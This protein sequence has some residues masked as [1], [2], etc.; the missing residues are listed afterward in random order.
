MKKKL[1]LAKNFAIASTQFASQ[2]NAILG[3]R[4]SGKT[5]TAMKSAEEVLECGIPIIVYDP[6][7][8]WKHIRSGV[9]GHRGYPVIVAGGDDD[10]DIKLTPDNA[11]SIVRA[12]MK[13][14]VSII[15]DLYS[16]DLANKSKWIKIVQE[17]I[18][19]LMYENRDHGL[20]LIYLEEAAEFI[21][22]RIMPQQSKVYAA[23]E[24]VARMGRNSSLGLCIINQ[25]AEEINKAI[26]ELCSLVFLHKQ[27]GKNSLTSI[28]KWFELLGVDFT[29]QGE[30]AIK[31]LPSLDK[32]ECM[33]INTNAVEDER[34]D[35]YD[36]V[37]I[38]PKKTFHPSP[39]KG[40]AKKSKMKS[41]VNIASFIK[42]LNKELSPKKE[43]KHKETQKVSSRQFA[44]DKKQNDA[45]KKI[46][47][48]VKE[49]AEK[50]ATISKLS[51]SVSEYNKQLKIAQEEIKTLLKQL[52]D[53]SHLT[54]VAI[55]QL[56]GIAG[57]KK[58]IS[59]VKMISS[60]S[61]VKFSHTLP[62]KT[63]KEL[64]SDVWSKDNKKFSLQHKG[65]MMTSED[66]VNWSKAS[67]KVKMVQ[68]VRQSNI[69]GIS[70]VELALQCGLAH[71]SGTYALY[72]R[73]LKAE[74][75][76]RQGNKGLF[77]VDENISKYPTIDGLPEDIDTIMVMWWGILGE[78]SGMTRILKSIFTR[79]TEYTAGKVPIHIIE[80]DTNMIGSSGTFAVYMRKLKRIGLIEYSKGEFW[81]SGNLDRFVK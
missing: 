81:L 39:E 74:G 55:M 46:A 59:K 64:V 38:L 9:K 47:V 25:R 10:A 40:L 23:I 48:F 60:V 3:I 29:A 45:V 72:Y 33:I 19:V 54:N 22:Q 30:A 20:R 56:K 24:Q 68:G 66:G 21:P 69:V 43:A 73:Q 80:S 16:R 12:A 70:K 49:N 4:D 58:F 35:W 34:Y 42:K 51:K 65:S 75:V 2:A 44:E 27:V 14:G 26:L 18:E 77:F 7:G 32:G 1:Q 36:R 5:Y 28:K 17:T 78:N 37:K 71:T 52:D 61:S 67:A 76:I 13:A 8:V 6:V 11:V 50:D 41:N 62:H 79:A 31:N 63:M 57:R 53:D 15:L